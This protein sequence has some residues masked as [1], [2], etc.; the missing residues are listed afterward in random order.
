MN[1][2]KKTIPEYIQLSLEQL[3]EKPQDWL[4]LYANAYQVLNYQN[5]KMIV[6]LGNIGNDYLST[7][8]IPQIIKAGERWRNYTSM[9][10]SIDWQ[11]IDIQTI[12]DYFFKKDGYVSLL[13]MGCFHSSGYFREK[14]LNIL[15]D[16]PNT[17]VFIM[18][19]MND[20]VEEVRDKAY[21]LS[22]WRISE[23]LLDELIDASYV[24]IKLKKSKR[25]QQ[26]QLDDIEKH[27]IKRLSKL[28]IE[29]NIHNFMQKDECIRKAFY[30][31]TLEY[32]LLSYQ[33][34]E[35][36]LNIE[37]NSFCL[38]LITK[39]FIQSDEMNQDKL[40]TYLHH[41]NFYVR[42]EA[43]LCYYERNQRIW[44]GIE[45]DLLDKSHAIREYVRFL[46]KKHTQINILEYYHD[47]LPDPIAIL[48]I[49]EVGTSQDID[50]LL[51]YL[52]SEQ[53]RIVKVTI[54]A[55]SRL[56]KEKGQ[57]IYWRF[58]LD[59]RM[60]L[61]KA[62]FQS[63]K[64]NKV[65][66]TAQVV[67]ETYQKVS[68]EHHSRYLLMI[69]LEEDSWE[70]LPYLLE[71]YHYPYE[72]MRQLIHLRV[73]QRNPYKKVSKQLKEKIMNSLMN[74]KNDIPH[75]VQKSILFDLKFVCKDE[76]KLD[77]V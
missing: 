39:S 43:M 7:M 65:H 27:Y 72:K 56:M 45:N 5:Q 15:V 36:L 31:I 55:L 19:R 26:A 21:A 75:N 28:L 33:L 64:K 14:C 48:G 25:R 58:L 44:K 70:R 71:L 63:I 23:S 17:L 47:H 9:L 60:T 67:Y 12:S 40:Y 46:L 57:D 29:L 61:S 1:F 34:I 52:E 20:W 30:Q 2:F 6:R 54:Q 10:W 3:E 69:L 77:E 22:Y 35:E 59:E 11:N 76:V 8:N 53:E 74:Q 73:N 68:I 24:F 38:L 32:G 13:I 50:I 16:Y 42:K 4:S 18:I 41:L 66:Y 51:P 37:K 62:A 49:S